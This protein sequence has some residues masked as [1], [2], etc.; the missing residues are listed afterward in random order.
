MSTFTLTDLIGYAA[1]VVGT[2]IMLPQ[3]IKSWR[4]KHV[5]DLSTSMLVLYLTNCLLWLAYGIQLAAGPVIIA[6]IAGF[7][8]GGIQMLLKMRYS[9][10][11]DLNA[12]QRDCT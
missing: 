7:T 5:Q 9:R 6:N 4:T 12:D 11:G 8:I 1:S 2:C 3:V 10:R